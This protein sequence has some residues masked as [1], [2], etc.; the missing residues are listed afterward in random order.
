M[1][2]PIVVAGG[3]LREKIAPILI[4]YFSPINTSDDGKVKP[5]RG[6]GKLRK[7]KKLSKIKIPKHRDS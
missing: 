5:Y 6:F 7:R 3:G 4:L 2:G 1:T